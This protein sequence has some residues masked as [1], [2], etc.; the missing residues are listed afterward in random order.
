MPPVEH[1][2]RVHGN[3]PAGVGVRADGPDTKFGIFRVEACGP[4]GCLVELICMRAEEVAQVEGVNPA[5][6]KQP[7]KNSHSSAGGP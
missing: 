4:K 3:H 1:D 7:R 5:H 2:I 6:P